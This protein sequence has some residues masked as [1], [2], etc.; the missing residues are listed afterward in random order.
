MSYQFPYQVKIL[1]SI[2]CYHSYI[3]LPTGPPSR[4]RSIIWLVC[5]S[6]VWVLVECLAP[7]ARKPKNEAWKPYP[8]QFRCWPGCP[9]VYFLG[10]VMNGDKWRDLYSYTSIIIHIYIYT[11]NLYTK[12]VLAYIYIYIRGPIFSGNLFFLHFFTFFFFKW[13]S[14]C[15]LYCFSAF[16]AFPTFPALPAFLLF[17]IFFAFPA[18][19]FF[20]LPAFFAFPALLLFLLFYFSCFCFALPAFLAFLLLRFSASLS[21][22]FIVFSWILFCRFAFGFFFFAFLPVSTLIPMTKTLYCVC[23]ILRF[24]VSLFVMVF[25]L[26]SLWGKSALHAFGV[27]FLSFF[28][29][30]LSLLPCFYAS[31]DSDNKANNKNYIEQHQLQQSQWRNNMEQQ[32]G[33]GTLRLDPPNALGGRRCAIPPNPPPTLYF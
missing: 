3:V 21:F 19:F 18:F 7:R 33:K 17:L 13:I 27:C 9:F 2:W 28:C 12:L 15:L 1:V 11:H 6:A 4:P 14:S 31:P 23:V 24:I 26:N 32:Q 8:V 25:L 20:A 22:S 16:L 10:H 29:F 30:C 5:A